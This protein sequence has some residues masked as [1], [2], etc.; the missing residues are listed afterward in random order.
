MGPQSPMQPPK[1]GD[2]DEFDP[3]PPFGDESDGIASEHTIPKMPAVSQSQGG[4][5]DS[6]GHGASGGLKPPS[7]PRQPGGGGTVWI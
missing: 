6:G 3:G 2:D 4:V 1:L 5:S 7:A